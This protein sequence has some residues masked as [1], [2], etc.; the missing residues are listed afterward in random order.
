MTGANLYT[1]AA[2]IHDAIDELQTAWLEASQHW[3]DGVSRRFC[4]HH[5]EPMAPIVKLALD[6]S[7][8][9]SHL[10]DHMHRDCDA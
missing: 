2:N 4:E 1:S 3:N 9:M 8:R 7:S 10:V 6:L 5:L